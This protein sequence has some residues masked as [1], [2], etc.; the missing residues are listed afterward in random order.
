MLFNELNV[1]SRPGRY[2]NSMVLVLSQQSS[3]CTIVT[4]IFEL[5]S[6]LSST[7]EYALRISGNYQSTG[8]GAVMVAVAVAHFP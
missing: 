8:L 4:T 1:L 2:L 6:I 3:F 7:Y 5:N